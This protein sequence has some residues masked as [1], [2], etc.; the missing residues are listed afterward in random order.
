V[1]H[2]LGIAMRELIVTNDPVLISYTEALLKDQ[3]IE[4]VVFDRNVSLM[5]GSIGAFPRRLVVPDELWGKAVD[6]LK[7]AGLG[8]WVVRNDSN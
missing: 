8:E 6:I 7:A 1:I 5:E 3:G 4:E 2:S